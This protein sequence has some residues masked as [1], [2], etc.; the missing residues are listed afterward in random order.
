MTSVYLGLPYSHENPAMQEERFTTALEVQAYLAERDIIVIS[1]I[2]MCHECA[3][4]WSLPK[5][6]SFWEAQNKLLIKATDC[7]AYI[8]IPGWEESI[9]LKDEWATAR[10]E[11]KGIIEIGLTF[12]SPKFFFMMVKETAEVYNFMAA[13]NVANAPD[14]R[15]KLHAKDA[16]RESRVYSRVLRK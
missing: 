12:S 8:A 16:Q 3:K 4:R 6:A 7:F 5:D 14:W 9:G 13:I 1:P 2:A 10:R 11:D 15:R